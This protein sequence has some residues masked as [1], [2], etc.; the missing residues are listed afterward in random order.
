M[1]KYL[2]EIFKRKDLIKY[3]VS[4]G[5]KAQHRN[6]FLGY[7]WWM[8]DPLLGVGVYYFLVVVV[9]GRGGEGYGPYLIVGLVVFRS[10]S[11]ALTSSAK[12]IVKQSSII[13]QIFLPKS[14]FP[15]ASSFS[16]LIN[17]FFGLLVIGIFLIIF[18]ILPGINIV[19]IPFVLL[20]HIFFIMAISLFLAYICVFVRDIENLLTHISRLLRYGSPVIWLPEMLPDSFKW[21]INV[22][23]L[24]YFLSS[25][26]NIILYNSAPTLKPLLII[27]FS[28]IVCIWFMLFYYSRHEHK[29]IKVL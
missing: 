17:F 16:Q 15:I 1:V 26:R 3:L 6:S 14:I 28:S 10:I 2:K 11:S 29:I 5:L 23:P 12:S 27:G 21:V 4:S 18:K 13:K 22:N 9:L 7:L 25:Y 24:T 19:W 8:L 20:I